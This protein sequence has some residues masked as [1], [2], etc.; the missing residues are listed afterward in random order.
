MSE[1]A[2]LDNIK[3]N[4]VDNRSHWRRAKGKWIGWVGGNIAGNIAAATIHPAL[5]LPVWVGSAVAGIK[6]DHSRKVRDFADSY[7]RKQFSK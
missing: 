4:H 6:A 7:Y 2:S 3:R 5:G 1:A